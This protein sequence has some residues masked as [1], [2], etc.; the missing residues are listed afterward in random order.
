MAEKKPPLTQQALAERVDASQRAVAGW[1]QGVMPHAKTLN[2]I[3]FALGVRRDWLLYGEGEKYLGKIRLEEM[4]P[5]YNRREKITFIEEQAPEL[6]P[7]VDAFLDS[8]QK[9]LGERA[10]TRARKSRRASR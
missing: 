5:G 9:Q 7:L 2:K 3:C 10:G 6:L 4:P 1:L 8:V